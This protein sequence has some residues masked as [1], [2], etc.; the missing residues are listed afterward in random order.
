MQDIQTAVAFLCTQVQSPDE[1]DYKKLTR[2]MQYLRC[3]REL[4]L[5]IEPSTDAKWW[6]DSSYPVMKDTSVPCGDS[7]VVCNVKWVRGTKDGKWDS[8]EN[9]V[10]K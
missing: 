9:K 2:V 1:D 3:T 5:T 6:I 7:K 4:T 8:H 10:S